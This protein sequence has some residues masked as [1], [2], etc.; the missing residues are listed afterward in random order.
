MT[1]SLKRFGYCYGEAMEDTILSKAGS[2]LRGHEFHH[3]EF[4]THEKAAYCM[5]KNETDGPE[6]SWL[7]GYSKGDTLASYLHLHFYSH[8]EAIERFLSQGV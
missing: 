8:L 3:S 4:H 5:K 1:K 6:Q 7:G 2:V